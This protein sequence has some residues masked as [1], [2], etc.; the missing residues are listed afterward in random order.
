M[1]REPYQSV[2]ATCSKDDSVDGCVWLLYAALHK[3]CFS[4]QKQ[5]EKTMVGRSAR[6]ESK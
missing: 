6:L 1:E 2:L 5:M 4:A 3:F